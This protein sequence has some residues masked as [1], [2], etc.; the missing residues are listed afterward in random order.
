LI[1]VGPV[2][3]EGGVMFRITEI[4][5]T[6]ISISNRQEAPGKISKDMIVQLVCVGIMMLFA[7]MWFLLA[8]YRST[9]LM[10]RSDIEE[11]M[12]EFARKYI[13]THDKE[14]ARELS[15]L[16]RELENVEKTAAH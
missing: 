6:L 4:T 14:I 8:M 5:M 2:E 12:D 11:R 16:A 13:E 10:S 3:Q 7:A 9:S 1:K 15:R